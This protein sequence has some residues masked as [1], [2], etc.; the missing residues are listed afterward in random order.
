VGEQYWGGL[1]QKARVKGDWLIALPDTLS[2][3][4]AM[5]IGTA[6]YTA[7]LC[8]LALEWHGTRP[9]DGPVLVTGASGGVGSF[10]IA[11]LSNLGYEVVASTGRPAEADYLK[12]LGAVDLVDRASLSAPG[13][14]L[15]KERWAAAVDSVGSHTLANVCA[16]IKA[17]G[18]V[19]A[20]G[21]AQGLDF[22]ASVAPFILRGVSLLGIDSVM[23]PKADRLVA[24]DR[25]ARDLKGPILEDIAGEITLSEV[26]SSAAK[27]MNGEVRGRLIVNV[28]A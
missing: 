15:Q 7:M 6:G 11:L 24:W 4:Q 13:K 20:C 25:L 22:P 12:K 8:V 9:A 21:M 17:N 3:R 16:Q 1:A 23:R 5:A 2:T 26:V 28:N 18:A 10:A 14:P 19:A 27:L